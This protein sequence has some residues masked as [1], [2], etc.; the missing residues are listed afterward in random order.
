MVATM[1]FWLVCIGCGFF[2]GLELKNLCRIC[3][4]DIAEVTHG[5]HFAFTVG[6]EASVIFNVLLIAVFFIF[7]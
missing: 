2:I 5:L 7:N 1:L 6:A 4:F 3:K